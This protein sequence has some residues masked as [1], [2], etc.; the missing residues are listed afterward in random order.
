MMTE[1]LKQQKDPKR[2]Q[3]QQDRKADGRREGAQKK[4]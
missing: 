2:A 3:E 4:K 1:D